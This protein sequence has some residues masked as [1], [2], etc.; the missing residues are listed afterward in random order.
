VSVIKVRVGKESVDVEI[1]EIPKLPPGWSGEPGIERA[2]F[3]ECT[4]F[5]SAIAWEIGGR[6]SA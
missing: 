4:S 2:S 5:L 1:P 6:R 3:E